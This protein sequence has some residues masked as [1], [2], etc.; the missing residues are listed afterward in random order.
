[1]RAGGLIM[2]IYI[3]V[4]VIVAAAKGYFGDINNISEILELIVAILIWPAV[5]FGVDINIGGVNGG[6]GGGKG[7][8]GLF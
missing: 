1:M 8:L 4:G 3:V 5:L 6:G 2:G 7:S